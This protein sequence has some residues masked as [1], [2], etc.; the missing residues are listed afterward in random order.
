MGK[1]E[2]N[3]V[4]KILER[5][6][7]D[8]IKGRLKG[9]GWKKKHNSFFCQI[10]DNFHCVSAYPYFK[11]EDGVPTIFLRVRSEAKPMGIDPIY[12]DIAQMPENKNE[13]LSFRAWAAFKTDPIY[14]YLAEPLDVPMASVG[15]AI[16]LFM[17]WKVKETKKVSQILN[18]KKFSD[19]FREFEGDNISKHSKP[20][21]LICALILEDCQDEA[22]EIARMHAPTSS[23]NLF[24][25]GDPRDSVNFY[26]LTILHLA[27]RKAFESEV[28]R[29][30]NFGFG[31]RKRK[32]SFIGLFR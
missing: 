24:A 22:L 23:R 1:R 18:S 26:E 2:D 17:N 29:K 20:I 8:G 12:W 25:D 31:P 27:G 28:R 11:F 6:I 19:V 9:T 7:I 5:E 4:A 3:K 16:D 14:F 15:E 10:D 21:T 32:K 13:P 30:P